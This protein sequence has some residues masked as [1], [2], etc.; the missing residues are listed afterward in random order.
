MHYLVKHQLNRMDT[1]TTK[2]STGL[3]HPALVIALWVL[4]GVGCVLTIARK[5]HS[6][7]DWGRDWRI[8]PSELLD[9]RDIIVVPGR[10]LWRGG[11]PYDPLTYLPAHP[12]AQEFDPYSPSWLLLSMILGPLPIQ[13]GGAIFLVLVSFALAYFCVLCARLMAPRASSAL[14]P[15]LFLWCLVWYPTRVMGSSLIVVFGIMLVLTHDGDSGRRPPF[16]RD[17]AAW[18]VALSLFKPQFGVPFMVLLLISRRWGTV[19][20]GLLLELLMALVPL[21]VA[22][23]SAGG[24]VAWLQS[25]IRDIEHAS[26]ADSA[27]GLQSASLARIDI[28]AMWMRLTGSS[29]ELAA[30]AAVFLFVAVVAL[31]YWRRPGTE[32]M[33]CC[34]LPFLVALPVHINYDMVVALPCLAFAVA[35]WRRR[36]AMLDAV[37][38]LALAV[39]VLHLHRLWAMVG[40]GRTIGDLTDLCLLLVAGTVSWVLV[41]VRGGFR[42]GSPSSRSCF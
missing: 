14:A 24:P 29:S 9:Y 18:G 39:V 42:A 22:I 28:P 34:W 5:V 31:S 10:F 3:K 15:L 38:V 11:N 8:G 7:P 19:V 27:A 30:L 32:S 16:W 41:V 40:I 6:A 35:A 37:V 23:V 36:R 26:S 21:T 17:A 20:R 25:V 1:M 12:W 13:V 33:A 4:A 2:L